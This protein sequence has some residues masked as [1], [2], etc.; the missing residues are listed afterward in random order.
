MWDSGCGIQDVGFEIWDLRF[1]IP[2]LG[3]WVQQIFFFVFC[4]VHLPSWL[5][6]TSNAKTDHSLASVVEPNGLS[7]VSGTHSYGRPDISFQY[8]LSHMR[9]LK[10]TLKHFTL[11]RTGMFQNDSWRRRA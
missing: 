4:D 2:G 8:W 7:M 1:R 5:D 9:M 6:Y 3:F 10:I 11:H